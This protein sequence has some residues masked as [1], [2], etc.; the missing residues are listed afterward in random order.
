[1]K[2]LSLIL[3]II[4]ILFF[5][6][7]DS[8]NRDNTGKNNLKGTISLSG[9]FALYPMAVK[10]KEEYN[11]AYPDVQIEISAGGAGKGIADALS[12]IVNLG[13]VSRE[14]YPS[15]IEKAAWF[16]PVVQDAVVGLINANNP[17]ISEIQKNGIQ[18]ETLRKI[19]IYGTIKTW[20]EA[21]GN[22]TKSRERIE[23]YTRADASGSADIWAKY[24]GKK[25][26]DLLGV[27]VFGDPGMAQAVQND[28]YGLGYGNISFAYNA[29]TK[30]VND[31]LKVI[32]L[33]IN[34]NY[35]I[36]PTENFYNN[37]DSLLNAIK[38]N[39]YPSPPA[40]YL[41]LLSKGKPGNPLVLHFLK[42]ILTDGQKY[43]R[44]AGF[45]QLTDE[46]IKESIE[47]LN[48]K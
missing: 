41:F 43:I 8:K 13:M 1:M 18:R 19:F 3:T 12:G 40:R 34:N 5:P 36:D 47:K 37:L 45:I 25:Q 29:E 15:E 35:T 24:F 4:V 10:W 33:D 17:V 6:G 7:C 44:E 21:I 28:K 20:G 14:I 2:Y 11:K 42:W 27:G 9:A 46:K 22:S 26:E 32:P 38:K 23:V 48:K 39:I 16:I 30:K 31:G